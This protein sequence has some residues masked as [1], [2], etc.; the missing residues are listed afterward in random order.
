VGS[1]VNLIGL[2]AM[3]NTKPKE[4]LESHTQN[5]HKEDK[6]EF[7]DSITEELRPFDDGDKM[8]KPQLT[9]M[10]KE[11]KTLAEIKSTIKGNPLCHRSGCHGTG[12]RGIEI[13][14]VEGKSKPR[15]LLCECAQIGET[16]YKRLSD[17]ITEHDARGQQKYMI[18]DEAFKMLCGAIDGQVKETAQLN[19]RVSQLLISLEEQVI[20]CH[21]HTLSGFIYYRYRHVADFLK[22][23]LILRRKAVRK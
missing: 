14:L 10:E 15:L 20:E 18:Y 9:D 3:G 17:R 1:G 5:Q 2:P 12:Q 11:L 13:V 6:M 4:R 7:E 16:E 23:K 19:A 22:V 21:R 8:D